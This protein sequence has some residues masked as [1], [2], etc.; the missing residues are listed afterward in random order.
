GYYPGLPMNLIL[1]LHPD[2]LFLVSANSQEILK[3]RKYANTRTTHMISDDEVKRDIEVSL[4]MISSLSILTGA[5]FEIIHNNDNMIDS[6]TAQMV[7][8]LKST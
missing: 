6:A 1:K 7:E 8:L 5:P 4:S 2:R 3:R